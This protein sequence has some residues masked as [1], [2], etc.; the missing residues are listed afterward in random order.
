SKTE[1]NI[2]IFR[3]Q[4][5]LNNVI[6]ASAYD[7]DALKLT[8]VKIPKT[9]A[10]REFSELQVPEI[11]QQRSLL[12]KLRQIVGVNFRVPFAN[13]NNCAHAA[14]SL[15]HRA[16]SIPSIVPS[17]PK[18]SGDNVIPCCLAFRMKDQIFLFTRAIIPPVDRRHRPHSQPG[19]GGSNSPRMSGIVWPSSLPTAHIQIEHCCLPCAPYLPRVHPSA[20]QKQRYPYRRN[21]DVRHQHFDHASP[22][23]SIRP[24]LR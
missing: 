7:F 18:S 14:I 3:Q 10:V 22:N 11:V 15:I 1:Q 5:D 21:N 9:V 19:A 13:T 16:G 4:F 23:I 6:L 12:A 20:E 17:G 2:V 8:V 24:R